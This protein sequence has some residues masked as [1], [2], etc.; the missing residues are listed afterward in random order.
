MATVGTLLESAVARLRDSGSESARLD[1]ELLLGN[2]VGVERTTIVAHPDAPVGPDAA[3]AFERDLA[4]RLRGEPVAYIRGF[5]EFH[6]LAFS[7]DARAL[8]PR[9]ETE[10]LVDLAQRAI[11][12]RLTASPRPPGTPPLQVVDVGTGAGT[13]AVSLAVGL[14]R[15]GAEADVALLAT[16]A[17]PEALG[18]ARE[19]AVG[20]GVA[21]MMTFAVADLLPPPS[22]ALT[23]YDMIVANL[24]YVRTDAVPTLPVAA[25]F[26]PIVALD[27]G[28]DGLRVIARLLPLLPHALA[29][30]GVAMLEI[31]FDQADAMVALVAETLP[32]WSCRIEPDL[33]GLP[34][35]AVMTPPS[36]A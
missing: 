35:V 25:S 32:G 15:L 17:S 12:T 27:G 33:A 5:K 31:G 10:T 16:D 19:N 24:P 14:R 36:E 20:H 29:P 30:R 8:I 26:E 7:V 22:D 23:G 13:I 2:A 11:V 9:P 18:L 34:R 21:D 4:R 6:G 28:A 1:A 3:A